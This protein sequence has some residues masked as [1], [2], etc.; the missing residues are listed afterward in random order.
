VTVEDVQR[1]VK[2]NKDG[3]K[4]RE[5]ERDAEVLKA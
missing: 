2:G 4:E 5:G 1:K 3:R